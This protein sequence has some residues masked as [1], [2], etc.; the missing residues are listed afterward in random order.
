MT[1]CRNRT[2]VRNPSP[3]NFNWLYMGGMLGRLLTHHLHEWE[4]LFT[5]QTNLE[6]VSTYVAGTGDNVEGRVAAALWDLYD[7]VAWV[8]LITSIELCGM[9][10][11]RTT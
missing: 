7:T 5:G 6:N 2:F 4:S 8:C 9:V 1:A 10:A 11:K 3:H